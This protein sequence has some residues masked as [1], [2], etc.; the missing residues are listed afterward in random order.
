MFLKIIPYGRKFSRKTNP[1]DMC[2][3]AHYTLYNHASFTEC[4]S[5]PTKIGPLE[6][7][8]LYGTHQ[9]EDVMISS[10]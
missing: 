1:L 9:F 3:H 6:N 7:F 8:P 2:S 5:L 4:G 10:S